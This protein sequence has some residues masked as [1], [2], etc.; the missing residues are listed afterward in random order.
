MSSPCHTE[1]ILN[2]KKQIAPKPKEQVAQKEKDTPEETEET[3][4]TA[5]E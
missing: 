4:L 2:E 3:K 5:Q 1:M